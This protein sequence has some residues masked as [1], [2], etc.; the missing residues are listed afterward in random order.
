MKP[1][2]YAKYYSIQQRYKTLYEVQRMRIDDVVE[3]L[4]RE[5]FMAER[6]IWKVLRCELAE[7]P[8]PANPNQMELFTTKSDEVC[9]G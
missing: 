3:Q 7:A 6:T 8:A 5:Y 9:T 2:T 4:G 1:T